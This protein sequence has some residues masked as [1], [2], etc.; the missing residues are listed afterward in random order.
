MANLLLRYYD[1]GEGAVLINRLDVRKIDLTSLRSS[2]GLVAQEPFLFDGTIRDNLLLAKESASEEEL[3][4]VL[5]GAHV[6][7][8]VTSLPDRLDTMI[9]SGASG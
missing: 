9:G 8:F 1:V 5:R 7:G 6:H 2:I 4:Q 3:W